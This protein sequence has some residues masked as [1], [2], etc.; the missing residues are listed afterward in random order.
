MTRYGPPTPMRNLK[1]NEFL[2]R[3][4]DIADVVDAHLLAVAHAARLASARFIISATTPFTPDDLTRLRDEA[5]GVVR[6]RF[7]DLDREYGVVAGGCSG[8]D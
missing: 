3:R 5:G 4:V 8:G 7:P 2:Y 6:E 1:A